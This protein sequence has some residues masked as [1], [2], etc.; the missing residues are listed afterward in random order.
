MIL[1]NA[2]YCSYTK[3]FIVQFSNY[4]KD[5]D[6]RGGR[7]WGGGRERQSAEGFCQYENVLAF[8]A[9]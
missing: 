5:R 7:K 9:D 8:P 6:K 3:F 1:G 2:V 4:K